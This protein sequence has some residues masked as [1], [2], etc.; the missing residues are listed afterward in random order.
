[1]ICV[2]SPDGGRPEDA[3]CAE[4]EAGEKRDRDP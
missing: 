1:M 2:T 3:E 4:T